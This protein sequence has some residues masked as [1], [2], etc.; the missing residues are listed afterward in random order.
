MCVNIYLSMIKAF[1][2][3]LNLPLQLAICAINKGF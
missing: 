2:I 3:N 1:S